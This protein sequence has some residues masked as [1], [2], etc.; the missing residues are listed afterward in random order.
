MR[1]NS[2]QWLSSWDVVVIR[3]RRRLGQWL[4]KFLQFTLVHLREGSLCFASDLWFFLPHS[5]PFPR[6]PCHSTTMLNKLQYAQM[7]NILLHFIITH[8]FSPSMPQFIPFLFGSSHHPSVAHSREPCCC[9][10]AAAYVPP[11]RPWSA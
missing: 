4:W 6:L 5:F 2:S 10:H 9:K 8:Y 11:A 7:I 1:E 3:A